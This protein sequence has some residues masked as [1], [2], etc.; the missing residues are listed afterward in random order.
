METHAPCVI[1]IS[2]SCLAMQPEGFGKFLY[3]FRERC[4]SAFVCIRLQNCATAARVCRRQKASGSSRTVMPQTGVWLRRVDRSFALFS[5]T[6][7]FSVCRMTG[8][9]G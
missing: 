1:R 3:R 6:M 9:T 8:V 4:D 5:T 2:A 7:A